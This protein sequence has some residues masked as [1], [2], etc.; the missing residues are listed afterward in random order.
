MEN[1]WKQQTIGIAGCGGLGGNLMENFLR[2]GI[3]HLVVCDGDVFEYSN[4]DRQ[5]LCTEDSIGKK[6][7]EIARERAKKIAPNTT[8]EAYDVFIDEENGKELFR[9]CVLVVDALDSMEGR[10]VLRSVCRELQIPLVHGAICDW[11]PEAR[12]WGWEHSYLHKSQCQ[13]QRHHRFQSA[14]LFRER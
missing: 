1:Q 2:L 13:P 11:S 6:K 3:T 12:C 9:D 10:S 7:V 4:M 8:V 14:N 5:I